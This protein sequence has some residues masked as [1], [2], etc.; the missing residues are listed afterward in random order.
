MARGRFGRRPRAAGNL[1]ALIAQLYREQRAAEDRVMF[2][3]Y[4][5]GGKGID[6]KPVTD[7]VIRRYIASRRDGFTKDD[8]LYSEWNNRLVQID[9]KIGEE[10][11]QLAFQEGKVGAGAVASFYRQQ[12]RSIPQDSAFYRDVAGRA[13]QWAKSAS[14]AARG[15]ARSRLTKALEAK[16]TGVQATFDNYSR[17][18]AILT[19]AAKRAGLIAGNQTLTDADATDLEAFLKQGV[20][21][22]KGTT[23]TFADWQHASVSAYKAF[24]IQIGINK[25]LNRGTKELREGKQKFLDQVVVRVNTIDDRAKYEV[26]REAFEEA[27]TDAKG[28]PNAVIAAAQAYAATL[29]TIKATAEKAGTGPN[30]VDAEFIG[31]L[32]NE[33][34]ILAGGNASGPTVTDL[35]NTT[36]EAISTG[37]A[38]ELATLLNGGTFG[39]RVV[40]GVVKDAEALAKGEAYFGQ[41]AFGGGFQVKYYPPG[42]QLDPFGKNGL[43]ASQQEALINIDGKPTKVVLKGQPV[44]AFGLVQPNGMP[45]GNEVL[46]DGRTVPV[47]NLSASQIQLLLANG[48]RTTE[49]PATVGFVFNDPVSKQTKYGVVQ[50]DGSMVFTASNPFGSTLTPGQNGLMTFTSAQV[51]ERGEKVIVAPP[52]L[53][54]PSDAAALLADESITVRDLLKLSETAQSTTDAAKYATLAEERARNVASEDRY[55]DRAGGKATDRSLKVF[56]AQGLDNLAGLGDMIRQSGTPPKEYAS[57]YTPPQINPIGVRTPFLPP[58]APSVRMTATVAAPGKEQDDLYKPPVQPDPISPEAEAKLNAGLTA[59]DWATIASGFK[60]ALGSGLREGKKGN[61]AL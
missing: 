6:G 31:A 49:Q 25:Q 41:D 10:K 54:P 59:D 27:V 8:P 19:T 47:D 44:L 51:D 4:Q 40:T 14:A 48:F 18:T 16:Q 29:G 3:A 43:D 60:N 38:Q 56:L 17:L 15:R 32:G 24:D 55:M 52:V 42:A 7:A 33:L 13:A 53:A 5:N 39:D 1:T 58:P 45:V 9:F 20:P 12:L 2:D 37:D 35:Q 21:G 30:G 34:K 11:V 36:T 26:A 50:P 23:I 46:I 22:P 57:A 28:D 61:I